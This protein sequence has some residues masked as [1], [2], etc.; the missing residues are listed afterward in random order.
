MRKVYKDL[1]CCLPRDYPGRFAQ[2]VGCFGQGDQD[3]SPIGG[4]EINA[5]G[6]TGPKRRFPGKHCKSRQGLDFLLKGPAETGNGGALKKPT[7]SILFVMLMSS[8]TFAQRASSRA[9]TGSTTTTSNGSCTRTGSTSTGTSTSSASQRTQSLS[10]PA[11]L[12]TRSKAAAVFEAMHAL[13]A[14]QSPSVS[15]GTSSGVLL[16]GTVVPFR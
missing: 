10:T 3:S 9:T 12:G 5:E 14:P 2:E 16:P 15:S 8:L 4:E 1:T 11:V 7:V 6:S 13:R